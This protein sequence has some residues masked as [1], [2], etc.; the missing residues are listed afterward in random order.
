MRREDLLKNFLGHH[1]INLIDRGVI[2]KKFDILE[3]IDDLTNFHSFVCD[4][5]DYSLGLISEAGRIRQEQK[6]SLIRM[7]R[8]QN[9]SDF[10]LTEL[11]NYA[12]GCISELSDLEFCSMIN[13]SY[14]NSEITL[15]KIYQN[16]YREK[17]ILQVSDTTR[18]RFGMIED[19]F[20]KLV[21]RVKRREK[22]IDYLAMTDEFVEKAKL[23]N[24]SRIYIKS[25]LDYPEE[26]ANYLSFVYLRDFD[27][28][29]VKEKLADIERDFRV[30]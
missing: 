6:N 1:N 7:K 13:R 2:K 9:E 19:D 8:L 20:I 18:I 25:A 28:E 27:D 21:K 29:K 12:S 4:K 14:K 10:N 26:A 3:A 24:L 22:D 16:L 30:F 23:D 5:K 17:D 15:G 11:I